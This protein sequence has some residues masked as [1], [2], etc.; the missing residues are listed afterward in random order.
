VSILST[1]DEND[2]C[3][4]LPVFC[5]ARLSRIPVMP[6]EL[7]DVAAIRYEMAQLKQHLESWT[8]N[9]QQSIEKLQSNVCQLHVHK[10]SNSIDGSGPQLP[11]NSLSSQDIVSGVS[12]SQTMTATNVQQP[13]YTDGQACMVLDSNSPSAL[14]AEDTRGYADAV[15]RP[16]TNGDDFTVVQRKVKTKRRI[17]IGGSTSSSAIGGVVKK[18]VVCVSRLCPDT[19]VDMVSDYLKGKG[20]NVV[21]CFILPTPDSSSTSNVKRRDYVSMRVHQQDVQKIFDPD[22]WPVGVVV[23]AWSFKSKQ[24][25]VGD[26]AVQP[27]TV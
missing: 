22:L 8:S 23:R 21:S 27:D 1:A 20:I 13:V 26:A 9:A 19:S 17:V 15:T 7:S 5:A 14:N 18:K 3:N 4:S 11:C 24:S 6:D 12:N 25:T 10:A 16:P 2:L